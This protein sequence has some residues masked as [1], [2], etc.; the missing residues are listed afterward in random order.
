MRNGSG[1][2]SHLAAL[3]RALPTGKCAILAML[4]LVLGALVAAGLAN[5]NAQGADRF[6]VL[7]GAGHD[8]RSEGTDISAVD[9]ECNA[10]SHRL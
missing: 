1:D 9:I 5:V 6:G 8:R 3:L 2:R 10:A 7:T 4:G